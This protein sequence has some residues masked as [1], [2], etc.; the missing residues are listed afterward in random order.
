MDYVY[1]VLLHSGETDSYSVIAFGDAVSAHVTA[2]WYNIYTNLHAEVFMIPVVES[3]MVQPD[4]Q[5]MVFK[6]YKGDE[7]NARN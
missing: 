1:L 6:F 7:K 4:K 3:V 5:N 2:N